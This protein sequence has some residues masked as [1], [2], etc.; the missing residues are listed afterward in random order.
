LIN[1]KGDDQIAKIAHSEEETCHLIEGGFEFVA[2]FG[3]NKI[4]KKANNTRSKRAEIICG[5]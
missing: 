3:S 4:L 2:D 1:F 5:G